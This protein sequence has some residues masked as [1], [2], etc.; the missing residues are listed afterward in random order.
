[1]LLDIISG[2]E[3]FGNKQR[4]RKLITEKFQHLMRASRKPENF[5]KVRRAIIQNDDETEH[6]LTLDTAKPF[7]QGTI[8]RA[9]VPRRR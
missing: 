8:I 4:L 2:E 9:S 7:L 3:S 5:N 6:S 1:M